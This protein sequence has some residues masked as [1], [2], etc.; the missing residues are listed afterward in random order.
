MCFTLSVFNIYFIVQEAGQGF[1]QSSNATAREGGDA[2][3]QAGRHGAE[4]P[5]AIR[6][7]RIF[8]HLLSR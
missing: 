6:G 4:P 7:A 5:A 3:E 2:L 1:Q 8:P